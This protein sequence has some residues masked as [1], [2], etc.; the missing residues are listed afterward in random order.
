[1]IIR[2]FRRTITLRHEHLIVAA[3]LVVSFLL[4]MGWDNGHAT[5][6]ALHHQWAQC[7]EIIHRDAGIRERERK[8]LLANQQEQIIPKLTTIDDKIDQLLKERKA[9]LQ[10]SAPRP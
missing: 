9:I 2:L 7:A 3:M 8:E 4:G 5:G 1:M 6:W 10:G